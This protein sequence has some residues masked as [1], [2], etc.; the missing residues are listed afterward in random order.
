L[1]GILPQALVS[2]T[3]RVNAVSTGTVTRF[4]SGQGYVEQAAGSVALPLMVT[5]AVASSDTWVAGFRY[6]A[7][8]AL[9]LVDA[10]LGLPAGATNNAGVMMSTSGQVCYTSDAVSASDV[11]LLNGVALTSDGP[12]TGRVYIDLV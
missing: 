4:V 7:D 12:G 2:A 8:G 3:G 11:V 5:E 10:T 6:R 1:N 9:R